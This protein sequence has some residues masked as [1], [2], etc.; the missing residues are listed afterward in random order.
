M[1]Q[2]LIGTDFHF[3]FGR[4]DPKLVQRVNESLDSGFGNSFNPSLTVVKFDILDG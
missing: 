3:L 1:C 2:C 4:V